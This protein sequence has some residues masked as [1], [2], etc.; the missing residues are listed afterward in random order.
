MPLALCPAPPFVPHISPLNPTC[1]SDD[2]NS[3]LLSHASMKRSRSGSYP[4]GLVLS[5]TSAARPEKVR[6]FK[7]HKFPPFL[8]ASL[9]FPSL[10]PLFPLPAPFNHPHH[11][12]GTSIFL[13]YLLTIV[14]SSQP[15]EVT[16]PTLQ[17]RKAPPPKDSSQ[18]ASTRRL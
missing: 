3:S 15:C 12:S 8:L 17:P 1:H 10:D 6:D 9:G 4:V 16:S 18:E 13:P 14:F 2:T 7:Q 5:R 11:P